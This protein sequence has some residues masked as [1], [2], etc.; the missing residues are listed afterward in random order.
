MQQ[1]QLRLLDAP[2]VCSP[3]R[4]M[5]QTGRYTMHYGYYSNADAEGPNGGIPLDISILPADLKRAN[6]N[7]TMV[8][9]DAAMQGWRIDVL[10]L[11]LPCN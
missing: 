4:T 1:P 5:L 6:Y 7:T 9:S 3:T 2:K 11:C 8:S 10:T